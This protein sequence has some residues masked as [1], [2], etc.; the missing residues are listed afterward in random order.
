MIALISS[1][2]YHL[3]FTNYCSAP[4]RHHPRDV[5]LDHG[6]LFSRGDVRC[7]DHD[8]NHESGEQQD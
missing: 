5:V 8:P 4:C 7:A 6:P 2:T 1:T 3:L